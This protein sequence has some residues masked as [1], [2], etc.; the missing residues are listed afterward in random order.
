MPVMDGWQ[1]LQAV[2]SEPR[3]AGIPVVVLSGAEDAQA[4]AR[5]IGI[6]DYLQ[7]PLP[8]EELTTRIQHYAASDPHRRQ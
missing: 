7:K 6:A 8:I 4:R 3:L 5:A 1:F 2:K